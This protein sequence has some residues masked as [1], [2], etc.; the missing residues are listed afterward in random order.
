MSRAI[1]IEALLRV[2]QWGLA[3][4]L[5]GRRRAVAAPAET[6]EADRTESR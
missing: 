4:R 2:T 1:V 6:R 5:G 3:Q